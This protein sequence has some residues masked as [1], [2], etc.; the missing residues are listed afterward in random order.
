MTNHETLPIDSEARSD[1]PRSTRL[2]RPAPRLPSRLSPRSRQLTLQEALRKVEAVFVHSADL[3]IFF[4]G[5]GTIEW[6]SAAS[7]NFMGV[8]P[9]ELIGRSGFEM[10]HPG[11]RD[12]VF[13]DFASITEPGDS[14]RTEFRVVD[15]DGR[16]RWI[17]EIA[18]N[19]LEESEVRAVVGNLRDITERKLAE[20]ADARLSAI[21][22]SSHDAIFTVD[23]GGFVTTW[24][25]GAE[26]LFAFCA[27]QMIGRSIATLWDGEDRDHLFELDDRVRRGERV[28]ADLRVRRADGQVRQVEIS[29]APLHDVH[30]VY[31]GTSSIARDVTNRLEELQRIEEDRQR[32]ADAQ[33]SARLGSFEFDPD[34]GRGR[35]SDE[36]CRLLG[37]EERSFDELSLSATHPEDRERVRDFLGA[38][39]TEEDECLHRIVRPDGVV[40]WVVT[41]RRTPE[42][43]HPMGPNAIVGTMLDITER[44]ETELALEHQ[45]SH[46]PLTGLL[47]RTTIV[48]RVQEHLDSGDEVA[49]AFLDLDQ[50]KRINDSL[51]HSTGDKL[52]KVVGARLADGLGEE[53]LI[54]RFGG[55][56]FLL[57]RPGVRTL[58][59]SRRLA[60]DAQ[61]ALSDP[62]RIGGRRFELTASIGVTL[63]DHADSAESLLRDADSAMYQAKAE[64]R[65][66][67][68]VFDAEARARAHRRVL[69]QT[70]LGQAL[71]ADELWL[72]YQ[73]VV[74][75]DDGRVAGFE[76]L[77]RWDHPTLGSV[78]PD[79]FIPIAERTGLILPI[80]DWVIE[81]AVSQLAVW[82]DEPDVRRDLWVAV[83]LSTPQLGRSELV[84]RVEATLE[85][86][87]LPAELLHLE[88]TESLLMDRVEHSMD[89]LAELRALGTRIS[90]DDFGTGHSSLS[91]L[92]RLA[93]DTLKIDRCFI[94]H[95]GVEGHDASIVRAIAALACSLELEVV[96]EGIEC[97]EQ[98]EAL[99]EL[100]CGFGQGYL[101]SRPVSP[102]EALRWM[103]E[104]NRQT[105]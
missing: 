92:S 50:F 5:D 81:R 39:H 91:Y 14:V 41:R 7:R 24:N 9:E 66:R 71:E 19:L 31:V 27:E 95:L 18:T 33:A 77:L 105:R 89:T 54:G 37:T 93:I 85:A 104:R 94:Q 44:Y 2:D 20:R 90:I 3:V 84:E 60:E 46:D 51:G 79:E 13:A 61:Q 21:V 64:G 57:V 100:G 80:G 70:A 43:E 52:L 78:R 62:V 17:E 11:A 69:I 98:L 16:V 53:D 49:L 36:L 29:I 56:E 48:A 22:E 1:A 102:A 12:R 47:N 72:A 28:V 74:D 58:E 38:K 26:R 73:P 76:A 96:A 42:R 88:I 45:A 101:W 35:R 86:H 55:D 67:S 63:S 82:R 75:L 99:R 87:S 15:A 10:I 8:E 6:V 59:D 32:L 34:T 30:G 65:A 103:Q 4:S 25:G 83:N 97:T 23:P 40:R 68:A